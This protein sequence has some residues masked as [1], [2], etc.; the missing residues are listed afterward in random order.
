MGLDTSL[1]I[2]V[3]LVGITIITALVVVVN[4]FVGM[5]DKEKNHQNI[6]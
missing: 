5:Q 6:Q 3:C 2:A 4:L 1:I